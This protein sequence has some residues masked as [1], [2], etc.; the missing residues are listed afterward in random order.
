LKI[1]RS[2]V[3]ELGSDAGDT[4]MVHATIAFAKFLYLS[5]TAEGIENAEQLTLLSNLRCGTG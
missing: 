1:D 3:N 4:G 2:Y 5:V